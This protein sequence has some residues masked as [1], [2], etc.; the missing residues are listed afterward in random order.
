MAINT[1][2]PQSEWLDFF[3]TFSNG[4]RGRDVTLEVIDSSAGPQGQARQGKLLAVGYDSADKGDDL[5]ITTGEDEV[6]H[7]HTITAPREVWRAQHDDGEIAALEIIDDQA[8]KT[9]VSLK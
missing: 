7:T 4:N 1:Q 3:V 2:I 8:C 9:I 6:D 5:V